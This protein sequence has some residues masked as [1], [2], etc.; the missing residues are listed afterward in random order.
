MTL[1]CLAVRC[2]KCGRPPALR[3]SEQERDKKVAY[4]DD[5]VVLSYKCQNRNCGEMYHITAK[6]Y[7]GAA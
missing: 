5:E 3:I 4:H 2:R 7:K 1:L 6:A